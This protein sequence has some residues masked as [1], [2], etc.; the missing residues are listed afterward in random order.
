MPETRAEVDVKARL[1]SPPPPADGKG[2]HE[3]RTDMARALCD[4]HRP[5]LVEPETVAYALPL[6]YPGTAV[7]CDVVGCEKPARL[8]L[9]QGRAGR[10]R[11][12]PAGLPRSPAAPKC[13]SR[14]TSSRTDPRRFPSLLLG[15]TLSVR[16]S[17]THS[18][19]SVSAQTL[20][21]EVFRLRLPPPCS[22]TA[23]IA[24]PRRSRGRPG[25]PAT[26]RWRR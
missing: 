8:W 21:L 24:L 26:L 6:G 11:R 25:S 10:F 2:R 4:D 22:V 3:G 1:A 18:S 16:S 17:C 12:R 9:L 13:G 19:L 15:G 14:T 23:K 7:T 5:E 20:D